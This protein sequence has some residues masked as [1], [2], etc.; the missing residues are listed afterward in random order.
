MLNYQEY[1][2]IIEYEELDEARRN[3]A[4]AVA[5]AVVY[6]QSKKI[7]SATRKIKDADT[8]EE[9]LDAVAD[10]LDRMNTKSNAIAALTY[11]LTRK[12]NQRITNNKNVSI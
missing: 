7:V 3:V 11:F 10:A 2:H 12:N 9:K 6:T 4:P 8:V 1:Q 5:A